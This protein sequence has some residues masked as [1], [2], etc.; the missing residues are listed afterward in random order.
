MNLFQRV[1]YSILL[2]KEKLLT[3]RLSGHLKGSYSNSTSK[4]VIGQAA[5]LD[6][7]AETLTNL[8]LVKKEMTE[9]V[10]KSKFSAD[11]LL[12]YAKSQ[13]IKA[14][15]IKDA[16]KILNLLREE[17]GFIPERRGLD[18]FI[19]NLLSNNGLS[20]NS[21]PVVVLEKDNKD[22]YYL[23]F[24]VYKICG[25]IHKLP[26]YDFEAQNLFK[27]Y[28]KFGDKADTSKLKIEQ[29]SALKEAVARDNEASTF[30][31]E[32]SK[33]RDSAVKKDNQ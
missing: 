27:M 19:L 20:Y 7:S 32:I 4:T 2:V 26:G 13:G 31:I 29:L 14:V 28:A 18:G 10:N 11:V 6:I 22:F 9:L 8:D 23:L 12:D 5:T 3:Y 24:T 21:K 16:A 1:L 17:Q 33:M 30:V 15:F 25:Y